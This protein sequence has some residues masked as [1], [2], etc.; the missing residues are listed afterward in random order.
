MG[1]IA[2]RLFLWVAANEIKGF[3]NTNSD[4]ILFAQV[5]IY[6]RPVVIIADLIAEGLHVG[7][8]DLTLAASPETCGQAIDVP[9]SML[10]SGGSISG[11]PIRVSFVG[12]AA[13]MPNPGAA[14]SGPLDEKTATLGAGLE[15]GITVLV[16]KM[17]ANAML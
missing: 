4:R 9:E 2:Y 12:H 8:A 3:D 15:P 10:K 17:V 16:G 7:C 13:M 5:I 14:I 6:V 1:L 11:R